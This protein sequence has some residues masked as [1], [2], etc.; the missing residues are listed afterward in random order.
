MKSKFEETINMLKALN[1]F[2]G[3]N[4]YSQDE[5]KEEYDNIHDIED[6]EKNFRVLIEILKNIDK[7]KD[8]SVVKNLI[9][10]H[11]T[12]SDYIWQYEQI[13]EMIKKMVSEYR[14]N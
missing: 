12:F 2:K 10:L 9:D 14:N 13:H 6:I 1:E 11:L 8:D 3:N 7:S 4:I 5:I